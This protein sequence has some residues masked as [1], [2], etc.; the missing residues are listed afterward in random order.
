MKYEIWKLDLKCLWKILER[1][2][3]RVKSERWN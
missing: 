3:K 2:V 1:N